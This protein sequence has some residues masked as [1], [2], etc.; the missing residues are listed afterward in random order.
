MT[1]RGLINVYRYLKGGWR[2]NTETRLFLVVCTDR[3]RSSGLKLKHAKFHSSMWKNFFSVRVTKLWNRLPREVVESPSMEI[4]NTCLDS[5]LCSLLW[6]ICFSKG[7]D[8]MI[9]CG[10]FQFL[11]FCDIIFEEFNLSSQ[12]FGS[13]FISLQT[14]A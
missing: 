5:Y 6:G 2:Q 10:P 12:K 3:T 13:I 4:L 1:T 8:S 14:A 11:Q 7:S 9:S